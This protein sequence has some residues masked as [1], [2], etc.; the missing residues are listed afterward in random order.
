MLHMPALGAA[1]DLESLLGSI[2]S[3]L[4]DDR[5]DGYGYPLVLGYTHPLT[6]NV[7][8]LAIRPCADVGFT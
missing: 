7:L 6:F 3:L 5:R 2:E 1:V 8:A 4:V